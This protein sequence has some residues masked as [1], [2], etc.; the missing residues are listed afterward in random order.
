M[1]ARRLILFCA[2]LNVTT[3]VAFAAR[4]APKSDLV[5]LEKRRATVE[6]AEKLSQ[7]PVPAQLPENL[8]QPFNPPGFDQP[9]PEEVR[10]AASAAAAAARAVSASRSVAGTPAANRPLNDRE[11][12]AAIAAKIPST[13]TMMQGGKPLLIVGKN[14][15]EVGAHFTVTFGTQ[16]HDLELVSIDRTTFTLRLRGEEIT[17][18]IKTGKSP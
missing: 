5:G 13:G 9:D 6:L 11:T 12:L 10:A 1:N 8:V 17:R 7:A 16:D 14:R 2:A 4:P 3:T 15:I 18:P